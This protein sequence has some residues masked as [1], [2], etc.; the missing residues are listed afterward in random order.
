MMGSHAKANDFQAI[1]TSSDCSLRPPSIDEVVAVTAFPL[2][3]VV[4]PPPRGSKG[5]GPSAPGLCS[6]SR[7]ADE[8]AVLP[9]IREVLYMEVGAANAVCCA[10]VG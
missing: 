6:R 2:A 9:L 5:A 10:E 7:L 4:N 1:E 8:V 3:P